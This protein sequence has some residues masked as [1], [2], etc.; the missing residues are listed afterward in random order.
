MSDASHY[1][2]PVVNMHGGRENIG[3]NYGTA[4][5]GGD[6]ELRAVV[7]EL[8]RLL[9]ELRRHLT[10]EQDRT[11]EEALPELV[12][13]L[14]ALRQRGLVLASVA[15]IAAAVGEVGRPVADA[16]GRLLGLLA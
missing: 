8:T 9:G 12:P 11:V 4:G 5:G 16:V 13:D 2:G 3:I 15:Q 14:A 1:Y 6:A 10:P 7:E